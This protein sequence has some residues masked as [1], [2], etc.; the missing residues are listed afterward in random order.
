M[1]DDD[2]DRDGEGTQ[3]PDRME[4]VEALENDDPEAQDPPMPRATQ[5]LKPPNRLSRK[6]PTIVLDDPSS[7]GQNAILSLPSFCSFVP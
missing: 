6:T 5:R 1:G 7:P 3:D 4:G 2:I